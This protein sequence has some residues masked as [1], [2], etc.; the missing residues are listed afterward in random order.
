MSFNTSIVTT[1]NKN[2]TNNSNI[3]IESSDIKVTNNS[4]I[5]DPRQSEYNKNNSNLDTNTDTFSIFEVSN[6]SYKSSK[7]SQSIKNLTTNKNTK[8][9]KFYTLS[10]LT[11]K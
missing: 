8:N 5:K 6:K 10:D 2:S 9:K 1:S 11:L 4:I 3:G 7:D